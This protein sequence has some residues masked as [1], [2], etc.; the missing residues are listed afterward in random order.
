M[1][2]IG[3]ALLWVGWYGFNGGSALAA[4]GNAGMAILVTHMSASAAALTWALIEKLKF[5]RA[6]MIGMATGVIAGLA[7]VTPASG[8]IGPVG[9]LVL[10]VLSGGLCF[11]AVDVVKHRLNVD[12]SLDVFAVH[13]VGGILGTLML[14]VLMAAGLGGVGYGDGG[15]AVAQL[16]AQALGVAAVC[17]WSAVATL[18]IVFVTRLLTG[19]R[20]SDQ[21]IQTG[22]DLTD[23]GERAYHTMT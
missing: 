18:A 17:A 3:A 22:L 23:H 20:H 19:W 12:D 7:T 2:L 21:A 14:S 10:G 5:G 4:D 1:T 16:G 15:G 11:L 8:F 13:G 9:G 6:S